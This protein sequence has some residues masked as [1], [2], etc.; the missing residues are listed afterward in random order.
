MGPLSKGL[1]SSRWASSPVPRSSPSFMR[2]TPS[3]IHN[4]PATFCSH[5][6]HQITP[7]S[8]I[9]SNFGEDNSPLPK[10]IQT[11]LPPHLRYKDLSEP[12]KESSKKIPTIIN[13]DHTAISMENILDKAEQTEQV[14]QSASKSVTGAP[15][16]VT[17]NSGSPHNV[18]EYNS[19]AVGERSSDTDQVCLW[20]LIIETCADH[21]NYSLLQSALL[22]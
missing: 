12:K 19:L 16:S 8:A 11:S 18:Y 1:E 3:P 7:S 17:P 10:S 6:L 2:S 22:Y 20:Y 15:K 21:R 13:Q 5:N 4:I 9:N 14:E